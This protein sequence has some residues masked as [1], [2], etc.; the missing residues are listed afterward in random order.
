M[1]GVEFADFSGAPIP[2]FRNEIVDRCF[3]KGLVTLGCG[4]STLRVAPPLIIK[5]QQLDDSLDIL[6][7]VIAELEEETW[8]TLDKTE[9]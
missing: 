7:R 5:K 2:D 3:V 1:I 9:N 8:E 4:S 6:E